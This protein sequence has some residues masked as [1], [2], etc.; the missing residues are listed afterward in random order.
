M[1]IY[2]VISLLI[3]LSGLILSEELWDKFIVIYDLVIFILLFCIEFF[4]N[5]IHTFRVEFEIWGNSLN[6]GLV[7]SVE[8]IF[9]NISYFEID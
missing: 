1:E 6:P 5:A 2:F 7:H 8:S 3:Y 9:D 4:E